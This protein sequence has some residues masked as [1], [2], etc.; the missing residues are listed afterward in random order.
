GK[1][2]HVLAHY[3]AGFKRRLARNNGLSPDLDDAALVASIAQTRP[4]DARAVA[5]L[6]DRMAGPPIDDSAV[7]RLVSEADAL[8]ER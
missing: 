5:A 8:L 3:R 1:R 7:L 2:E 4:S 6:L